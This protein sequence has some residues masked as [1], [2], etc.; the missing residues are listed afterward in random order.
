M[1]SVQEIQLNATAITLEELETFFLVAT[2]LPETATDKELEWTSSNSEIATVDR[3]GLVQGKKEGE[4][5]ITATANNGISASVTVSVVLPSKLYLYQ[6]GEQYLERTGGFASGYVTG[7]QADISKYFVRFDADR[8]YMQRNVRGVYSSGLT[9]VRT[10]N[11]IDVTNYSQIVVESTRNQLYV[12]ISGEAIASTTAVTDC[13]DVLYTRR[14][15]RG[16]MKLDISTFS[17]PYYVY[18]DIFACNNNYETAWD[19][20]Q[21]IYLLR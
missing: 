18:V 6:K 13:C 10:K 16:I 5:I 19:E 7:R 1:I 20:I 11:K 15:K 3:H 4:A 12:G 2:I 17:G 21:S 14:V 9:F 8:I